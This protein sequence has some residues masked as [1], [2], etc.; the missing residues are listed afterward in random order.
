MAKN[1]EP[2]K[3]AKKSFFA[4]MIE[5]VEKYLLSRPPAETQPVAKAVPAENP[6]ETTATAAKKPAPEAAPEKAVASVPKSEPKAEAL[7][8]PAAKPAPAPSPFAVDDS[9]APFRESAPPLDEEYDLPE[10]YDE[11]NIVLLVR[12]PEWAYVYW[13]VSTNDRGRHGLAR[14][15]HR[16]TTVL[17]VHAIE[18]AEYDGTNSLGHFDVEIEDG[19]TRSQYLKVEP[20]RSFVVEFG[21]YDELGRFVSVVSSSPSETPMDSPAREYAPSP[22]SAAQPPHERDESGE[23]FRGRL[24]RLYEAAGTAPLSGG[25]PGGSEAIQHTADSHV[26]PAD[27]TELGSSERLGGSEAITSRGGPA[28]SR[29]E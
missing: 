22:G 27:L 7:A 25:G 6:A 16:K 21:Y 8:A 4:R 5:K 3:P 11:T 12:D 1:P 20:G 14:D 24:A 29:P 18:G 10:S 28:A 17:R 26:G 2:N 19:R 9:D 13:D 15:R 23:A